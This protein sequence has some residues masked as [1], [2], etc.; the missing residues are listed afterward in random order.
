M[1]IWESDI[2]G[3]QRKDCLLIFREA[4]QPNSSAINNPVVLIVATV[5]KN[6]TV[7]TKPFCLQARGL[8]TLNDRIL[9]LRCV[10]Y[11]GDSESLGAKKDAV[12]GQKWKKER[13]SRDGLASNAGPVISTTCVY[14]AVGVQ[15][16]RTSRIVSAIK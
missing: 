7:R 12:M 5:R 9:C 6:A 15:H 11:L 14:F 1:M 4:N 16:S 2:P 13:G 3:K 8:S 10:T